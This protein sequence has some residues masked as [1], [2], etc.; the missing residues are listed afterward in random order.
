MLDV[1]P[2]VIVA[3]EKPPVTIFAVIDFLL[4]LALREV[5]A[6][7][8][9]PRTIA[10]HLILNETSAGHCC[11]AGVTASEGKKFP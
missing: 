2:P 7:N 8:E 11:G 10:L 5:G 9:A 4:H 1:H 6:G 3:A